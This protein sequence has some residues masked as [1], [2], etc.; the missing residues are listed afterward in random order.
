MTPAAFQPP[1]GANSRRC[2]PVGAEQ[3]ACWGTTVALF[4]DEYKVSLLCLEAAAFTGAAG[5]LV[6][7]VLLVLGLVGRFCRA[8]F[9][10]DQRRCRDCPQRHHRSDASVACVLGLVAG[11]AEHFWRRPLVAG[12]L[13]GVAQAVTKPMMAHYNQCCHWGV[14]CLLQRELFERRVR[15]Q[16]CPV[17]Q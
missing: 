6:L 14:A 8:G 12:L 10:C 5:E 16:T 15:Q 11:R 2:F 17:L 9:V 7:P 1:C 3:A 13:A 4:T